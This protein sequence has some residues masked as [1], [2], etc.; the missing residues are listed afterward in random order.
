MVIYHIDGA[1]EKWLFKVDC[2][3]VQAAIF[4]R[5]LRSVRNITQHVGRAPAGTRETTAH[6]NN[7]RFGEQLEKEIL[8]LLAERYR[9]DEN[10]YNKNEFFAL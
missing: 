4:A 9:A 7:A 6:R 10:D 5:C 3:K 8:T 1:G 2:N